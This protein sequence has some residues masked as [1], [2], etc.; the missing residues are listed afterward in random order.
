MTVSAESWAIRQRRVFDLRRRLIRS[1]LLRGLGFGLLWKATISGVENVPASGPTILMM[2][3]MTAI[4]PLPIMGLLDRFVVPMSKIENF[5]HP[6]WGVLTR[7]WGCYPVRR[8]E[9]DRQALKTTI[10]LLQAGELVLIAPEGTRSP[11]LIRPKDG[12]VY[13]ALKTNPVIVPSAVFNFDGWVRDMFIPWKRTPIHITF[14]RPFRLKQ[15][16]QRIS[17]EDMARITDE[18]MYQLSILLPERNRG[19]YADLSKMTADSLIFV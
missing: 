17:R 15:A 3:H 13:V 14:G 9:V 8:G 2:N 6:L 16:G 1:V 4:D 12:L 10:D 11:A 18:M 7:S 5:Q 19:V